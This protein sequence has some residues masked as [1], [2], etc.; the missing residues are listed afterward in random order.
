[1]GVSLQIWLD[2]SYKLWFDES[3]TLWVEVSLNLW[4]EVSLN[5]WFEVSLNLW[6]DVSSNQKLNDTSKARKGIARHGDKHRWSCRQGKA[7]VRVRGGQGMTVQ[8]SCKVK[9]TKMKGN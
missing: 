9:Q 8:H 2:V 3:F 7:R 1:M 5:L 4:F 6:F